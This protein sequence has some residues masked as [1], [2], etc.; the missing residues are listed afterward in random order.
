MDEI[1]EEESSIFGLSAY[2][3]LIHPPRK[4]SPHEYSQPENLKAIYTRGIKD[5]PPCYGDISPSSTT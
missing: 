4:Y 3:I 1:G 2:I 5:I